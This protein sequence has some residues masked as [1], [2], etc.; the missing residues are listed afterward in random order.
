[1]T[2]ADKSDSAATPEPK[3]VRTLQPFP[4]AGQDAAT[5]NTTAP[6][7]SGVTK[8]A[9]PTSEL[10]PAPTQGVFEFEGDRR[11]EAFNLH[12]LEKRSGPVPDDQARISREV[13]EV[14]NILK[15]LKEKKAFKD[16]EDLQAY[17]EF[18]QRILQAADLGCVSPNVD[19]TLAAAALEQIRADIVRR[20]GRHIIYH[21][22]LTLGFCAV[23][24]I[25]LAATSIAI[26]NVVASTWPNL[27]FLKNLTGYGWVIMGSMVGAWL[28]VAAGR[29]EVSF[30]GIPDFLNLR[31]EPYIR[32]IFVGV[33]AS[34]LAL[35]LKLKIVEV[36]VAGHALDSFPTSIGLAVAIGLVAG[37]GERALSVELIGRAQSVLSPSIR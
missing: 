18:V 10:P 29:R 35:F 2:M 11:D 12:V 19:T 30:D 23:G 27:N 34:V 21:Y 6:I 37:I 33:L 14:R 9:P 36:T 3:N 31:H 17:E 20:K 4:S 5:P 24:G 32:M 28:S 7:D 26:A 8:P 25:V 1:M 22:L 16:K 13:Y 15:L